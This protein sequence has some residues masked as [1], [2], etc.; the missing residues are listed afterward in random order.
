MAFNPV[1]LD[2]SIDFANVS[3]NTV[4]W[5]E[6]KDQW[7]YWKGCSGLTVYENNDEG[8]VRDELTGQVKLPNGIEL[9][10]V[11]GQVKQE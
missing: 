3:K 6:G 10:I 4:T 2:P 1:D 8:T 5:V 7:V 9:Y 11:G